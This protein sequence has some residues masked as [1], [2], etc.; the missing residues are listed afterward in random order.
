MAANGQQTRARPLFSK[1]GL[2]KVTTKNVFAKPA[3]RNLSPQTK[4]FQ[5]PAPPPPSRLR[6]KSRR[7]AVQGGQVGNLSL[8]TPQPA[9]LAEGDRA[10]ALPSVPCHF[11]GTFLSLIISHGAQAWLVSP[12]RAVSTA[13][14][15]HGTGPA[16]GPR[17]TRRPVAGPEPGE[18]AAPLIWE[19]GVSHP[20]PF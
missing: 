18:E 13:P 19:I 8:V 9:L 4:W 11:T 10:V 7:P 12:R 1:E 14:S 16:P 5:F 20:L 15:F 6:D 17:M 2:T 3:K